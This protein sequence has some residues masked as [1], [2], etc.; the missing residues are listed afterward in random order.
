MRRTQQSLQP[1][2]GLLNSHKLRHKTEKPYKCQE[3]P[4]DFKTTWELDQ[5][6]M[7][8]T[9]ERPHGC[10]VPKCDGKFRTAKE[11]AAHA[12]ACKI[13]EELTK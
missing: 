11:L 10:Q 7:I 13:R 5:H 1:P 3:C 9:D 4:A 6:M 2:C 8:H 12:A